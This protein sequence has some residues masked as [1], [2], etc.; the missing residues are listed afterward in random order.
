MKEVPKRLKPTAETIKFLLL[1]SGNQCAFLGCEHPIF[2]DSDRLVAQCCHIEAAL[3]EGE[4]FNEFASNE[5]RR[6]RSNLMFLCY[7]HHVETDD[8]GKFTTR[9]MKKMKLDHESKFSGKEI[10]VSKSQ[11]ASVSDSLEELLE[12]GKESLD[13]VKDIH[14]ILDIPSDKPLLEKKEHPFNYDYYISR[15]LIPVQ[16]ETLAD[17]RAWK[18]NDLVNA[19]EPKKL[20]VLSFA[21]GGKSIELD[22]LHHQLSKS[23][24]NFYPVKIDLGS[25]DVRQGGITG[26]LDTIYPD[27]K[28]LDADLVIL[29]DGLDEVSEDDADDVRKQIITL[30][31]QKPQ[32]RIVVMCRNN[33]Y[34]IEKKEMN[35]SLKGFRSYHLPPFTDNEVDQYL[36]LKKLSYEEKTHFLKGLDQAGFSQDKFTPFYLVNLVDYY[37][38]SNKTLPTS[39]VALFEY[40][41]DVKK[42]REKRKSTK[43]K[44]AIGKIESRLDE[45]IEQTAFVFQCTDKNFLVE[46]EL[47]KIISDNDLL[48]VIQH[49]YGYILDH[50]AQEK[51]RFEHNNF[52]EYLCAK[53][54]A[55]QEFD[56]VARVLFVEE[57]KKIKPRWLNTLGFLI[58]ILPEGDRKASLVQYLKQ[59]D[60]ESL[61]RIE[62]DK[63]RLVV[64]EGV[65]I[66]IF[67]DC[68]NK[69]IYPQSPKF[70]ID[71]LGYFAADS[72]AICEFLINQIHPKNSK[73]RINLSL[74]LLVS[75]DHWP[76]R[77]NEIKA[78]IK[79]V[80]FD[81]HVSV[82]IRR[83][84]LQALTWFQLIDCTLIDEL[85]LSLNLEE[86]ELREGVY[87]LIQHSSYLEDYFPYVWDYFIEKNKFS[88]GV[89]YT[90]LDK[91]NKKD[92]FSYIFYHFDKTPSGGGYR[93]DQV[94]FEVV[95]TIAEK[96]LY[97]RSLDKQVYEFFIKN[98]RYHLIGLGVVNCFNR[99]L[100]SLN[101]KN[102][103]IERLFKDYFQKDVEGS[104]YG[105][106]L[107]LDKNIVDRLILEIELSNKT[108][109]QLEIARNS[110]RWSKNEE[111]FNYFYSELNR[112][113]KDE[114]RWPDSYHF[115]DKDRINARVD[116]LL[117]K[118]K[119]IKFSSQFFESAPEGIFT[120]ETL[121]TKYE[122][123]WNEPDYNA[124]VTLLENLYDRFPLSRTDFLTFVN[125]K[126]DWEFFA[127]HE[128]W[129]VLNQGAKD[130]L[131]NDQ[132]KSFLVT[133]SKA[134]IR[135][136][137]FSQTFNRHENEEWFYS[138]QG[139]FAGFFAQHYQLELEH[140]AY[141]RL[142][143]IDCH[144][145]PYLSEVEESQANSLEDEKLK[146]SLLMEYITKTIGKDG[147]LKE[148]INNLNGEVLCEDVCHF[149]HRFLRVNKSIEYRELLLKGVE[150]DEYKS[151]SLVWYTEL[152]GDLVKVMNQLADLERYYQWPVIEAVM[153]RDKK[154]LVPYILDRLE[155]S[156]SAEDQSNWIS[157]LLKSEEDVALFKMRDWIIKQK[158]FP[159]KSWGEYAKK[160]ESSLK[161]E[162]VKEVYHN[163]IKHNFGG[164]DAFDD[165][166]SFLEGLLE[167]GKRNHEDYKNIELFL[168]K[169][170]ADFP[171]ANFLHAII[172]TFEFDY[173]NEQSH[174]MTLDDAIG[175][176]SK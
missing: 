103:Y 153:L 11:I 37:L 175:L 65:F 75:N 58:S 9:V 122:G 131:P 119:F 50:G 107:I 132:V 27:W 124:T 45:A 145:I 87:S 31:E 164:H 35:G 14:R 104:L 42:E 40:L 24:S 29:I 32:A 82:S 112:I 43:K 68:V 20:V 125:T 115:T 48:D 93:Q 141:T 89:R 143:R 102:E 76:L 161:I 53:F 147:V 159:S 66:T 34:L 61:I 96:G 23:E 158:H 44:I 41:I 127:M 168:K 6:D 110:L 2:D 46:K 4:R 114:L 84:C 172:D 146:N 117:N 162:V 156:D 36:E 149:H 160:N 80:L 79:E 78:L 135:N 71:N 105:I 83:Q 101:L 26:F 85:F 7:D 54:L 152:E 15:Y 121:S 55:I 38:D 49:C 157:Y 28:Q 111:A 56:F 99:Y 13:L 166:R 17:E 116:I 100:D 3:P 72:T 92:S 137:G 69:K 81:S 5:L 106:A 169:I 62:R 18:L 113:K 12:M 73:I 1:R 155:R 60:P 74:Y 88:R 136:E 19:E 163:S 151:K 8:E 138:N 174:S 25:N 165:R 176:I 51:W 63:L 64:R 167:L 142:L 98:L 59:N 70:N 120:W 118:E 22:Y 171:E 33:Q 173:Y 86:E 47:R 30:G 123:N 97:S 90:I 94:M 21:G 154:I 134:E 39:K 95:D 140:E 130:V 133:W 10:Q 144:E 109:E 139:L 129:K 16:F 57:I 108:I 67:E 150:S 128:F 77:K 91:L 52:K 170:I 148:V 126:A